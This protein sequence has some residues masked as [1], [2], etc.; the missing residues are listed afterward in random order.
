MVALALYLLVHCLS[1]PALG[2]ILELKHGEEANCEGY[3]YKHHTAY[4]IL[5]VVRYLHDVAICLVIFL[6]TVTVGAIWSRRSV[7]R[8]DDVTDEPSNY[9]C[10][11]T[12]IIRTSIIRN[13]DYPDGDSTYIFT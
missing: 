1:I 3:V 8:I 2:I 10:S 7:Y 9:E 11:Q 12:S 6:A 4:W 5:D 13:L